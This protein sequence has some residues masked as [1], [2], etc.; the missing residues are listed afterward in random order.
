M[1]LLYAAYCDFAQDAPNGKTNLIGVF[2]T[3]SP[4]PGVSNVGGFFLCFAVEFDSIPEGDAAMP[5]GNA[6]VQYSVKSPHG[7]SLGKI[8]FEFPVT[9][10]ARGDD[11][12]K[13]LT[14]NA[15]V[16]S[17]TIRGAGRYP[18]TI[19]IGNKSMSGPP[20]YVRIAEEQS[21]G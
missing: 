1:R 20:L 6:V 19:R 16:P 17:F 3:L 12:P 11:V 2:T 14:V 21:H 18:T 9:K 10:D 15:I 8:R 13:T 5:G 4:P 7:E